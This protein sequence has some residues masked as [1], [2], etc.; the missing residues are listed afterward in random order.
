MKRITKKIN[1]LPFLLFATAMFGQVSV[2][3][4]NDPAIVAQHKRMTFES[5]GDW[6][7]YPK[8]FLGIQTNFAYATVWGMWAPKINRDYKNGSDIRPLKPTGEQNL[9]FAQLKFQQEQAESIKAASDTIYKRSVQDFAHWTAT[10]VDADPLW[11]L[12]YKRMLQPITEFPDAP[13]N[14]I[15]WGLNDQTTYEVL[16]TTGTLKRMQEEL[17]II[18]EK[19][20]LSRS[21][22]MP[23]G[24]R[25]IM[26]HETLIRWRK[27]LRELRG[28][29]DKATFLTEYRM[30]LK[31]HKDTAVPQ[32]FTPQSDQEIMKRKMEQYK[33]RY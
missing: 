9:R 28:Y 29:N 7:P 2:K 6:R 17:D 22:D 8:Y 31:K 18:K 26:Y 4:L 10:T 30:L 19:Y 13:Q 14:F 12:Y 3:R 1:V 32:R 20:K 24:K 25:F 5:W 15:Q 23:R 33:H 21:M 16:N 27:F 11:L